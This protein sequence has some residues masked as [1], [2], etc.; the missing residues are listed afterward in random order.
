[1]TSK[2]IIPVIAVVLLLVGA[3]SA[4]LNQAN[5]AASDSQRVA[6][7]ESRTL[8][9]VHREPP[10][11][12]QEA[13]AKGISGTVVIEVVVGKQGDVIS[14]K[15]VEGGKVLGDAAMAAIKSWKFE[16]ATSQGQPVQKTTRI[17]VVF[18]AG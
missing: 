4:Q 11:Y 5:P 8:K 15:V 9:V 13:K 16:P 17:T 12:P 1:V 2:T 14:A 18:Q 3:M 6:S 10:V 7:A